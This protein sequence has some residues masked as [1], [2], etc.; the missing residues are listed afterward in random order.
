MSTPEHKA[1]PLPTIASGEAQLDA[2]LQA[3]MEAEESTPTDAHAR[4]ALEQSARHTARMA[5]ARWTSGTVVPQKV[6]GAARLSEQARWYANAQDNFRQWL[7]S[8]GFSQPDDGAGVQTA[9]A[10]ATGCANSNP[11][12]LDVRTLCSKLYVN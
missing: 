1:L 3:Q 11:A 4:I 8:G 7:A 2:Q 6:A 9:P 5:I 10:P 12:W